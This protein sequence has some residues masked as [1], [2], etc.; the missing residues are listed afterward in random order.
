MNYLAYGRMLIRVRL[1]HNLSFLI[2]T[3][4]FFPY[5][6]RSQRIFP[7]RVMDCLEPAEIR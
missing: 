3:Q 4:F 7:H 5:V 6:F 2:Y 1:D